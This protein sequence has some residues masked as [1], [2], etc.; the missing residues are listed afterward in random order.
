MSLRKQ[1][2]LTEIKVAILTTAFNLKED[3]DIEEAVEQLM[4]VSTMID[5]EIQ[6]E[7]EEDWITMRGKNILQKI[8]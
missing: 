4:K 7:E 1:L 8:E 3:P 2:A 6:V 5:D